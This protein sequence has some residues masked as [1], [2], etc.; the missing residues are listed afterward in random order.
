MTSRQLIDFVENKLKEHG[1]KKVIPKKDTLEKTYRMFAA[2]DRLSDMPQ[3]RH[4]LRMPAPQSPNR[5]AP[6]GGT[7]SS[8]SSSTLIKLAPCPGCA[9]AFAFGNRPEWIHA[10]GR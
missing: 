9:W 1:I 3:L 7:G 5:R 6:C 8:L 10:A 4:C 2:S